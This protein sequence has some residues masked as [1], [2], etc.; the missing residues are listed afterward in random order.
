MTGLDDAQLDHLTG[1]VEALLEEPWQQPK[2]RRRSLTIRQA[3][4]IA[5]GYARQNI[6]EEVWAEIFE[7][8]QATVSKTI[9]LLTPLIA[10]VTEDCRP[11]AEQARSAIRGNSALLDGFLAPCWSWHDRP[12]LWSGKHKT[13]GFNSQLVATV[14]GEVVFVSDPLPGRTHDSKAA[15]EADTASVLAAAFS[16]VADKGYQGRGFITPIKKPLHRGLVDS[17]I[18]YNNQVSGVRAPV[19]R[20]ISHLK[21]WRI[22]HTDYRRPLRT[23]ADSFKAA[24]GLYFFKLAF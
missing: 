17:E 18:K 12:D 19:E 5:C 23:Y 4:I 6:V 21:A 9:T 7:V 20:A 22:L 15:A 1:A 8:S 16:T 13:T 2:G 10:K 24:V 11:T 14:T 3:V